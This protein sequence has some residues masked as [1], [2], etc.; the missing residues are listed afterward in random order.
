MSKHAARPTLAFPDVQVDVHESGGVRGPSAAVAEATRSLI[1][2]KRGRKTV[3]KKCVVIHTSVKGK[4]K[5]Q[6]KTTHA[7]MCF[8]DKDVPSSERLTVNGWNIWSTRGTCLR[9]F[10]SVFAHL[11]VSFHYE[12]YCNWLPHWKACVH[13]H[14]AFSYVRQQTVDCQS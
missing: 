5:Q 6:S 9:S 7:Q 4:G 12:M 13:F 8:T 10:N 14:P 3:E 11:T 2:C 1:G